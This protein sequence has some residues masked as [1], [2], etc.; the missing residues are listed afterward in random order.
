MKT[1]LGQERRDHI[2]KQ[3]K[4]ARAMLN[5]MAVKL[6]AQ[7]SY[8]EVFDLIIRSIEARARC[9]V[10]EI[11]RRSKAVTDSCASV[12]RV[13]PKGDALPA[14]PTANEDNAP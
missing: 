10:G 1:L 2:A 6:A 3:E 9:D 11:R 14:R 12:S 13:T 8:Y 4:L 7:L 5:Q